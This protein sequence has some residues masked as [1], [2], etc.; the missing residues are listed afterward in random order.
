[1]F[2]RVT[3]DNNAHILTETIPHVRSISIGFFVDIG[4]RYESQE[5]NGISHFIEHMMF[6]GTSKRTAKD[7]ACKR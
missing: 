1:M 7:I 2:K 6:K 3:L 5:I 4:S